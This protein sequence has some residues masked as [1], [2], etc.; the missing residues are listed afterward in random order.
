MN[1]AF[2]DFDGTITNKDSLFVFLKLF[3]GKKRFYLGMLKNMH[4]LLGYLLGCVSNTK[5]KEKIVACFL[6]GINEEELLQRSQAMLESFEKIIRQEA[7]SRIRWHQ[8][9]GD[10]VV[11]VSATFSC[12]LNPLAKKLGVKC[13]ATELE[14]EDGVITGRFATPNCYGIEKVKRI[15]GQY[16]LDD[17]K[18]I[19]AYGDSNGDKEMLE[20]ATQ[21]FYRYFS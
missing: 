10:R 3:V 20:I 14:V 6:K 15:K 11:I 19:Y 1:I 2:F 17:Y 4:Y 5:A 9:H 16:N 8:N 18:K 21:S 12:Y 7:L 13:I